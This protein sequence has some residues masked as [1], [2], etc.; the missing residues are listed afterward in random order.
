MYGLR[1]AA[2]GDGA[3]S[4]FLSGGGTQPVGIIDC[5][6]ASNPTRAADGL[7]R[8]LDLTRHPS[9]AIVVTH[10][11][12][13]HY[14]GLRHLSRSMGRQYV[15]GGVVLV[16]A[17][18]PRHPVVREYVARLYAMELV[19]GEV[20]GIPDL[21]LAGELGHSCRY[22]LRRD[23]KSAGETIDL[24]GHR[25]DV[26]WPPAELTDDISDR[27]HRAIHNFDLLAAEDPAIADA[28]ERVREADFPQID[29]APAGLDD[30]PRELIAPLEL[31]EW[32]PDEEPNLAPSTHLPRD[33]SD[34][35]RPRYQESLTS[36]VRAAAR[37]FAE[38]ANYTSLVVATPSRDFVAWGDVP[39]PLA[40]RI[41]RTHSAPTD[42]RASRS[43]VLAPHHGSQGPTP[44]T[45]LPYA[46]IAQHGPHLH[47]KWTAKHE[48]CAGSA[49]VSTF[50]A[51]DIAVTVPGAWW[52]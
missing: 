26:L 51:G 19:L 31:D 39:L 38:A 25:L 15:F 33:P 5:G 41:A 48:P 24:G 14:N 10:L 9:L 1:V 47:S 8:I 23:S 21:D 20:S 34:D 29:E 28:L 40:R 6:S 44:S 22:G 16:Q 52:W 50:E 2:A 49:C 46:C 32:W 42:R 43:V 27:V 12:A 30:L 36:Q 35:R 37:A 45:G 13:D 3:C 17:R 4:V 11:H 7:R 18:M